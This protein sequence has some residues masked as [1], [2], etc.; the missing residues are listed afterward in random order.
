VSAKFPWCVECKVPLRGADLWMRRYAK[1]LLSNPK[2]CAKCNAKT[3][4]G[5]K[6]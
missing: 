4:E 5:D 3:T 1:D 2:L 6:K